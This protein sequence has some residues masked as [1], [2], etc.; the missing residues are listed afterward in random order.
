MAGGGQALCA[1]G[2]LWPEGCSYND[3]APDRHNYLQ[4]DKRNLS[5]VLIDLRGWAPIGW[6]AGQ[7]VCGSNPSPGG[8]RAIPDVKIEGKPPDIENFQGF[9]LD[10][11]RITK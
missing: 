7:E 9:P 3:C 5:I 8:V 1:D 2:S 11:A 4:T 10:S 6:G